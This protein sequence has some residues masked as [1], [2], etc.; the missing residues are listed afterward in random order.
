MKINRLKKCWI[1][2]HLKYCEIF[3]KKIL[4][5]Y[6]TIFKYKNKI[7]YFI[8]VPAFNKRD[9][10]RKVRDIVKYSDFFVGENIKNVKDIQ[11]IV[12]KREDNCY[13]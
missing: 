2:L 7:G 12:I 11:V 1:Y 3:N 4:T 9:A 6:I 8:N 5:E 13:E 10:K